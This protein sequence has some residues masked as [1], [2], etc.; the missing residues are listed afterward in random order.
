MKTSSFLLGVA[1]GAA[2]V[3]WASRKRKGLMSA[4]SNA[5][6]MI[7]FANLAKNKS[8]GTFSGSDTNH[9]SSDN[10]I[11]NAEQRA[12]MKESNLR[13]IKDF[14]KGNPDVKREVDLIMK[15]TNTIIPG[16]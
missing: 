13:T 3:V 2:G 15:E 6:S 14:I 8:N 7:N 11:L 16:L 1:L 5:G 12:Q 9:S 4:A 10:R